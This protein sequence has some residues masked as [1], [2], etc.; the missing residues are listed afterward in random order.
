[1]FGLL[2]R[3]ELPAKEPPTHATCETHG[4]EPVTRFFLI[5]VVTKKCISIVLHTSHLV[6]FHGFT[7]SV[8]GSVMNDLQPLVNG[9]LEPVMKARQRQH[10]SVPVGEEREDLFYFFLINAKLRE[11]LVKSHLLADISNQTI[12]GFHAAV[13]MKSH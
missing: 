8:T 2:H 10:F 5:H 1:M 6:S 9:G 3:I 13:C 7:N 12:K 11:R 4:I